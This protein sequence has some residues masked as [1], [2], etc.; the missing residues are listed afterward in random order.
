[1]RITAACTRMVQR[2]RSKRGKKGAAAPRESTPIRES[3]AHDAPPPA[4]RAAE[5]DQAA[6]AE[7]TDVAPNEADADVSGVDEPA[8]GNAPHAAGAHIPAAYER[9]LSQEHTA[10]DSRPAS[11]TH[12]APDAHRA[13]DPML[14]ETHSDW[15]GASSDNNDTRSDSMPSDF[16][17]S[18]DEEPMYNITSIG[19]SAQDIFSK[20]SLSAVAVSQD[21]IAIGMYSGM[22]YVLNKDG[23]LQKGFQFHTAAVHRLVFDTTGTFVGS[24]GMDGLVAIA[25]LQTSEQYR[26]DFKRPVQTLALEPQF[27]QRSSRAFVCGGMSGA[28][29]HREKRWFGH[30]ETVLHSGEGPIWAVAWHGR[31]IAWANERGV[32]ILDAQTHE[33]ITFIPAPEPS[34]RCELARCTLVWR[35]SATLLIAQG[36]RITVAHVNTRDA[37]AEMMQN[38]SGLSTFVPGLSSTSPSFY[39]EITD[40]FQ[41]DSLVAGLA[42]DGEHLVALAYLAHEDDL[43]RL[44]DES[45]ATAMLHPPDVPELRT[46]NRHG[47]EV[48]SDVLGMLDSVRLRCNDYHLCPVV[49]E[50]Q[51]PVRRRKEPHTVLYLATPS[52]L[53]VARPRTERD[54]IDW[55]LERREY[56]EALER[57]EALGSEG[58]HALGFDT[59]AIGREYLLYLVDECDDYRGAAALFPLLLRRDANAWEEMVFLYLERNQLAA[60]LPEIPTQDPELSEVAYDMVLVHLLHTD[61]A[62]LLDTLRTW[63]AHLYSRQAV[64]AAIH[65]RPTSSATLLACLAELYLAGRQPG[66]ALPYLVQLR[67]PAVFDLIREHNLFTDVQDKLGSLVELDQDLAGTP[68]PEASVVAPLLVDHLHSIPIDRAMPQLKPYPWYQYLYLNALFERDPQLITHYANLL[69]S[70]YADYHYA[71]LMPFLRTMSYVYSFEQA[72]RICEKHDYVPEMVFLLGRTGDVRGALNLII[73]RLHDV[74]MAVDFVKQQDDDE[75]WDRLLLYSQD[76]PAFIRG[77]LEHVGGEIDPVRIIRPIREGLAIDGLKPAVIKILHTIHLQHSLLQ[78]CSQVQ[79][80]AARDLSVQHQ[81]ALRAARYCDGTCLDSPSEYKM[82]R[83]RRTDAPRRT[84]RR[85][86]LLLALG[87][88]RVHRAAG[89]APCAGLALC[90]GARDD[91]RRGRARERGVAQRG[92]VG[93]RPAAARRRATAAVCSD[94]RRAEPR[95]RTA[96]RHVPCKAAVSPAVCTHRVS[97]VC[98]K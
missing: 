7:P 45:V 53:F 17:D 69:V 90:T 58:A 88:P 59:S 63:P 86:L 95:T 83:V 20:D 35:A 28:L 87:A 12:D 46:I 11:D 98:G 18:F 4:P 38:V 52:Q 81:D 10:S 70:L 54:H 72:Y 44:H 51:N 97:S 43:A 22:I 13:A 80:Q 89:R 92:P 77:L 79:T 47:E 9:S 1:M 78:G 57:L 48:G 24:A 40:I 19:W 50:W 85:A 16:S 66:K 3:P 5:A 61:E 62:K 73:E 55:L 29:I 49:E 75:L 71:K 34:V 84:A 21:H 25:S 15:R 8:A 76:K 94:D 36:Q 39:V 67:D 31:W 91:H 26:F 96:P 56:R 68:R 74:T 27:G 32:R 93:R 14:S 23:L 6:K 2:K 33:L 37:P 60:V 42:L 64:V 30:K 65:D 82:R 41:L